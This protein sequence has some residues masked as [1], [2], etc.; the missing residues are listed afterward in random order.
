[1]KVTFLG[2]RGNIKPVSPAHARHTAT[3][4]EYLGERVLIDCGADWRG[5]FQRHAPKAIA[6]THCHPDHVDGLK[7]G[8]DCPVYASRETWEA[9]ERYPIEDR[10]TVEP[11]REHE[12]RGMT[13]VYVPVRHSTN[14][15]AGGYRI[16]AGRV[17]IFY[18]PDVAELPEPER[19]LHRCDPYI[20]DGATITRS[21]VRQPEGTTEPIGHASIRTQLEWCARAGV[22]RAIFTHCGSAVVRP[23]DEEAMARIGPLA[24]EHGLD[25]QFATDGMELVLR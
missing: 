6:L 17:R 1:M 8:A 12:I 3:L 20:G 24:R 11:G 23:G 9:I 22:S 7:D 21:M 10:R 14:C 16:T 18:V 13:F 25:V 2:T 15:P 5:E 19:A 4:V